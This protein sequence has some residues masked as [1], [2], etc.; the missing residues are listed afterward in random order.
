[1]VPDT[2]LY[3]VGVVPLFPVDHVPFDWTVVVATSVPVEVYSLIVVPAGSEE[4]P[5]IGVP[6]MIWLLL[7]TL[8]KGGVV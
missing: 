6:P 2:E 5:V 1:V 4:V 7:S 8:I 3:T